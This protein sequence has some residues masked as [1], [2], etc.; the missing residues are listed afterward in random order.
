MLTL[1]GTP[2][3]YNGEEIGMTDHIITDRQNFA[4]RWQVVLQEDGERM[5]M[6]A[7]EATLRAGEIMRDKNARLYAVVQQTKRGILPQ[8][9]KPGCR[10]TQIIRGG[11]ND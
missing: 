8:E 3:L 6:H 10:S 5:E 9:V 2:F 7:E 1:K 11:I 4:T